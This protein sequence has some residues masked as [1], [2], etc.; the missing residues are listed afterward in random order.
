M[1]KKLSLPL[2]PPLH[3]ELFA[4]A[5][6]DGVPATRLARRLLSDGLDEIRRRRRAEQITELAQRFAGTE[7]DLDTG[8]AHEAMERLGDDSD[9]A[10]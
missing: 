3:E 8:L 1:T 6:R 2:P 4:E 9:P 10:R 5:R 7:I